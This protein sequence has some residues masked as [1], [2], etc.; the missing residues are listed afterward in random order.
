MVVPGDD[1]D[2]LTD[3]RHQV[4]LAELLSLEAWNVDVES[5]QLETG[6]HLDF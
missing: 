1:S 4:V 3:D 6:F 5:Y 2:V